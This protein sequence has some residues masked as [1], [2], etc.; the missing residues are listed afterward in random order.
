MFIITD[1][2]NYV[3]RNPMSPDKYISTTSSVQAEQFTYKQARSLIRNKK[4]ALKWIK[5]YR[6]VDIES[7]KEESSCISNEG[8][9]CG[10]KDIKFDDTVLDDIFVETDKILNMSGWD[11][12]QLTTY[13]NV[14]SG[15]LSKCDSAESDIN[16]A[17][18]L[19][20]SVHDGKNPQAHK[21]AK[22]GY[23]ISNIR[24]R[25]R[26]IK[27]CIS[28]IEIMQNAITYKYDFTKI[29]HELCNVRNS[30]YKGRTEYYKLALEILE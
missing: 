22:L 29:K 10:N 20:K 26:K 23:M 21:I 9:F 16:H 5:S 3:M 27:Q 2:K 15:A 30:E 8:V 11:M 14:L 7:G 6:I 18:E 1:G 25:R 17:L 13:K 24:D 4:A 28:Y 12:V 19:Y